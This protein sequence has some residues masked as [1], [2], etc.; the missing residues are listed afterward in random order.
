MPGQPD[1]TFADL[2][3]PMSEYELQALAADWHSLTDEAQAALAAE[4]ATRGLTLTQPPLEEDEA[5]EYR[6]LVTLRRYR[7]LSEAIVAR[8]AIESAG[9]FCFLKDENTIRLDWQISNM[10]GG[11]RLQVAAADVEAA[12]A[13]LAQP[14]PDTIEFA[15]E[16]GYEQ[17]R[18]PRCHSTNISYERAS[19]K[20]TLASL[21]LIGIPLPLGSASWTC[22]GCGFRWE[23]VDEPDSPITDD[24]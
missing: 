8:G 12:E 10:I 11:I 21:Y 1:P 5:P 18:C 24:I 19:R 22:Q 23:E 15:D 6:D 14:I 16:P 4:F 17:P 9:I 3:R 20:A 7:D 2:Y 13:V